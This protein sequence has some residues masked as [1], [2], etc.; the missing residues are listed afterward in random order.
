MGLEAPFAVRAGECRRNC[1]ALWGR[2]GWV[3]AAVGPWAPCWGVCSGG[4]LVPLLRCGA[5]GLGAGWELHPSHQVWRSL[6]LLW[7]FTPVSATVQEDNLHRKFPVKQ[8]LR[9]ALKK[10]KKREGKI[11]AL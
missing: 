7:G 8:E 4:R 9:Q 5:L 3:L 6:G 11:K 1:A 2:F 10:K